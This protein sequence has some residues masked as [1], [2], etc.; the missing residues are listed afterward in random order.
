VRF[1]KAGVWAACNIRCASLDHPDIE[2]N[3]LTDITD[4][5]DR[6]NDATTGKDGQAFADAMK[7]VQAAR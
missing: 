1:G 7:A 6:I 4:V 5:T 2:A 3:Q